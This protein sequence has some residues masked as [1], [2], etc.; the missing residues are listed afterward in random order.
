MLIPDIL[1]EPQG[2]RKKIREEFDF[3]LGD[4]YFLVPSLFKQQAIT[5]LKD[6]GLC[7]GIVDFFHERIK[8]IYQQILWEV[9]SGSYLRPLEKITQ[10]NSL[11]PDT[12]MVQS[13][14]F[15]SQDINV[16]FNALH[17][18]TKLSVALHHYLFLDSMAICL[19]GQTIDVQG[20]DVL[21]L[22][23]SV[24]DTN[25]VTFATDNKSI[26]CSYYYQSKK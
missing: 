4:G 12:F 14:I 6:E 26:F 23:P 15:L 5:C 19:R 9:C 13:G 16:S 25:T 20:G 2:V 17:P 21:L 3:S 18:K 11:I 7:Y 22:D 1:H 10:I 24:T 8:P